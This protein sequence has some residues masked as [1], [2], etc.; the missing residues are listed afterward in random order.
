MAELD[1]K[2]LHE[3]FE[4]RDG[5]LFWKTTG[6][7]RRKNLKAG[8]LAKNNY[9]FIGIGD[10]LYRT[11]KLIYMMFYGSMPEEIDHK[12]G[13][14]SNNKIENLRKVDHNH[15]MQNTKKPITN[16]S[17]EKNV[18][19]FKRDST[20][21]VQLR[22]NGKRLHIGYFKDFDLAKQAAYV[23]RIQHHGE[24]ANHG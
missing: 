23:A 22:K 13:N 7:G 24:Y 8:Y 14:R 9:E 12:D 17:G 16:T 10:K 18:T 20:W 19:W 4:Y 6:K 2:L 5:S 11:H 21:H 1:S 3:L 15:N